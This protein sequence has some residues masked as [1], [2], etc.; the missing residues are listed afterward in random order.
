MT[1]GV[2]ASCGVA[3]FASADEYRP[4]R[5][6]APVAA[7]APTNAWTGFQTGANAGVSSLSQNFAEP[8]AFMCITNPC[9]ETPFGFHGNPSSFTAGGFIGYRMQFGSLVVG[10]ET[11]AAWKRAKSSLFQSDMTPQNVN[12]TFTGSLEQGWDGSLRGRLGI[13]LTPTLLAYGTAGAAIG[14][15][16]GSFSYRATTLVEPTASVTGA[17]SWSD[18]RV[19][20][21]V[22][23]GLETALGG[24]V[25]AR[26]EYRYTDFG[27]IS[28]N[29][30]LTQ[31]CPGLVCGS[32][33]HIDTHAAF[34]TVRLGLGVDF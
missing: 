15:V 14:E 11:D 33:A 26:I 27:D 2:L 30:P 17:G 25:K 4:R 20:Y 31:V 19:G 12:E 9:T 8:G 23:G 16:S 18:T 1:F 32:N 21:T 28:H 34:N 13:L 22:G 7:P 5:A 29:I 6:A 24:G 10:V 3:H